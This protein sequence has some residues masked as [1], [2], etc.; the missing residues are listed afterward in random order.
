MRAESGTAAEFA[1]VLPLLLLLTLGTIDVGYYAYR[2]NEAEKATQI[3]ARWA[4]VTDP[5]AK[6]IASTN[7]TNTF[8]GTDI[9]LQGEPIPAGALGKISCTSVGC[10]CVTSP[11]P[12]TTFDPASFSALSTRMKQI[13]PGLEDRNIRVDYSGSGL[14]FAGDPNGPD[15]APLITVRLADMTYNSIAL[16]PLGVSA[17]LPDFAYSITAEDSAGTSSN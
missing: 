1:L 5:L 11:C 12:G 8:V 2:I 15:I 9:I 16:S 13:W 14:G 4:A 17:N 3:G 10:T 6:E 7:Y